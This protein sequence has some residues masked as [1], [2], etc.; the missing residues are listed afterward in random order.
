M[1]VPAWRVDHVLPLVVVCGSCPM[2]LARDEVA[3]LRAAN[4]RLR[5]MIEAKGT[6]IAALWTSHKA[7]LDALRAQVEALS[8]GVAG[9]GAPSPP[10][11]SDTGT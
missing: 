11:P 9:V 5:P 3:A 8:A 4:V 1:P 7:Q 10:S 2:S 6:E